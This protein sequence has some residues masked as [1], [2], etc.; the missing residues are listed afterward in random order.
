MFVTINDLHF[1][2]LESITAEKD[3]ITV[4]NDGSFGSLCGSELK[5]GAIGP[6]EH[7]F[8]N[9]MEDIMIIELEDDTHVHLFI[10]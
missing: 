5:I 9:G 2:S 6:D 10:H 4:L 1:M 8:G 3:N 7:D